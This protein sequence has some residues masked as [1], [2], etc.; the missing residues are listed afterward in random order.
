M[1]SV[2]AS[3]CSGTQRGHAEAQRARPRP[4]VAVRVS[5]VTTPPS[6]AAFGLGPLVDVAAPSVLSVIRPPAPLSPFS[7]LALAQ[8]SLSKKT[9]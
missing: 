1:P 9:V 5:A 6:S 3:V 7:F 2:D 8:L 4:G